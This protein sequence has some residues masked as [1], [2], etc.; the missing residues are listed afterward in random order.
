MS[1]KHAEGKSTDM[2]RSEK[3]RALYVKQAKSYFFKFK[4]LLRQHIIRL[5][6]DEYKTP[7]I[8]ALL[9]SCEFLSPTISNGRKVFGCASKLGSGKIELAISPYF[10]RMPIIGGSAIQHE[11]VHLCQEIEWGALTQEA[12]EKLATRDKVL[13]EIDALIF[14]SPILFLIL[15]IGPI[16]LV[17]SLAR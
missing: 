7:D 13:A 3:V 12:G 16:W 15:S 6:N 2:I 14:G 4:M 5:M 17:Q 10:G 1:I 11:L 9:N 8:T